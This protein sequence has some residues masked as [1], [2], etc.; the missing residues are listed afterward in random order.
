MIERR[1]FRSW[2]TFLAQAQ[3]PSRFTP[4]HAR[5]SGAHAEKFRG[6]A[7]FAEAI[8]LGLN[9]WKAGADRATKL[10]E[11]F[12]LRLAREIQRS[13]MVFDVTGVEVD[14]ARFLTNEPE[15]WMDWDYGEFLE[16]DEDDYEPEGVRVIK[17][18]VNAG[19]APDVTVRAVESRGAY[20]VGLVK[21]LEHAGH[22]VEIV[23]VLATKH[24]VGNLEIWTTIKQA[25]TP[26]HLGRVAFALAHA[27]MTRRL[28][29][30]VMESLE[31]PWSDRCETGYGIPIEVDQHEQ[32]D[33]YLGKMRRDDTDAWLDAD[34]AAAWL[35]RSLRE[36]GVVLTATKEI[37]ESV[38]A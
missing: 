33:I 13:E 6:T 9:G 32:G 35:L 34:K 2:S 29:F 20:V 30:S 27:S 3:E 12:A 19:I 7:T 4:S 24:D 8:D 15:H 5:E 36:N 38:C 11:P 25:S 10:V 26:L 22:R 28:G 37:K 23:S 21:L 16:H 31:A 14:M 18:V 1:F 17:L